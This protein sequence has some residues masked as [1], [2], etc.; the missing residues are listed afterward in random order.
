LATAD[1][2]ALHNNINHDAGFERV[3]RQFLRFFIK[4]K[5]PLAPRKMA[6]HS[7]NSAI[8]HGHTPGGSAS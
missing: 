5:P 7:D 6:N 8:P 4:T 2:T 1:K 3:A